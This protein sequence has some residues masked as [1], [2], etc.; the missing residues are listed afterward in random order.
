VVLVLGLAKLFGIDVSRGLVVAVL[1]L[2]YFWAV[3]VLA[4]NLSVTSA[5]NNS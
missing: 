1:A 4:E 2:G 5:S 3:P